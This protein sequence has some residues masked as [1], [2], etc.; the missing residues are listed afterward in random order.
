[1][2]GPKRANRFFFGDRYLFKRPCIDSGK[3]GYKVLTRE[4][5]LFVLYKVCERVPFVNRRYTKGVP[6]FVKKVVY[7]RVRG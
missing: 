6:F 1:M 4:D 3:K 7:K 2:E 5:P